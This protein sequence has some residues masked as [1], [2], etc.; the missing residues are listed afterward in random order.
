MYLDPIRNRKAFEVVLR[1]QIFSIVRLLAMNQLDE[2][3]QRLAEFADSE[4]IEWPTPRLEDA[5]VSYFEKYDQIRLDADAR[6]PQWTHINDD[7]QDSWKVRQTLLDPEDHA[8]WALSI[9]IDVPASR[10]ESRPVMKLIEFLN[11]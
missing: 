7:S 11:G 9:E 10:K 1:N 2:A 6:N 3:G 8:E 5:L 4:T